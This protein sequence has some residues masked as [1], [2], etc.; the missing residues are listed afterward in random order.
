MGKWSN[1]YL[2]EMNQKMDP[3]ADEVV[4]SIL[5]QSRSEEIRVNELFDQLI[6]TSD[7]IPAGMPLDIA[8]YFAETAALPEWADPDLIRKGE[9]L[10]GEY[11]QMIVLML[12]CR[13]LPFGYACHRVAKVMT[14]TGRLVEKPAEM[15][16]KERLAMLNRRVLETAQFILNMMQPGGLG[17]K[18]SGVRTAQKVRLIHASIRYFLKKQGWDSQTY[19]APINQEYLAATGLTFSLLTIEGLK[20][21]GV[22]LSEEEQLAYLQAWNVVSHLIGVD[23]GLIAHTIPDATDLFYTIFERQKGTSEDCVDLAESLM[24]YMD[25]HFPLDTMNAIPPFMVEKLCGPEVAEILQIKA[26]QGPTLR[27]MME[28]MRFAGEITETLDRDSVVFRELTG[29]LGRTLLQ[30]L[31]K[32]Y[33]NEKQIHFY[34]SPSLREDWS[35]EG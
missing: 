26:K 24:N 10:F 11:G 22:K 21:V 33:N 30:S 3:V 20:I 7:P 28:A 13:C 19:G 15:G 18:G 6:R 32:T 23:D 1:A 25:S 31:V 8:K 9:E 12:F 4:A 17:P 14:A 5:S 2:D 16:R 34:I 35:I 27:L 29:F